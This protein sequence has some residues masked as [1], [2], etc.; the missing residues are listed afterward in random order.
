MRFVGIH[1]TCTLFSIFF[2]KGE[3][4]EEASTKDSGP[5]DGGSGDGTGWSICKFKV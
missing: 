5:R 1:F 2:D 3:G 4:E